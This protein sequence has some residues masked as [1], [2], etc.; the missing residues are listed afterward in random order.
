MPKMR[1]DQGDVHTHEILNAYRFSVVFY[2][3]FKLVRSANGVEAGIRFDSIRSAVNKCLAQFIFVK[4]D[5]IS[6]RDVLTFFIQAA[7]I[8]DGTAVQ[9]AVP[10]HNSMW[11]A[12]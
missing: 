3:G 5:N 4:F 9:A 10:E 8:F 2:C 11:D 6:K 12:D 7:L 1:C